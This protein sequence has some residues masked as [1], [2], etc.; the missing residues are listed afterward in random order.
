MFTGIIKKTG[1]IK[2]IISSQKG[3]YILVKST[4]NLSKK[5]IGES[6]NVS[7]VCLTLENVYKNNLLFYLS[8]ETIRASNFKKI[9][10]TNVVN[11]EPSLKFGN[12]MSGHIVQGHVD[13]TSKV[14]N[15]II[16]GKSWHIYFS[17]NKNI[18]KFLV[19]K[20]SISINGISLTIAKILKNSFLVVIIPQTLKTT[21]LKNIK[22]NDVVNIEVDILA[23]YIN[24][25]NK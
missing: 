16:Q 23:K 1:V 2:K 8:N 3:F 13:T 12:K 22:K 9:K 10:I 21:N 15:K 14:K 6:I 20:G 5:D 19:Y 4:L 24:K 18:K 11:L 17:M 25:I 7:G